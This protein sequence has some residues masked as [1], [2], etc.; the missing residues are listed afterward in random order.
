MLC[1]LTT[2][3]VVTAE[4][5]GAALRSATATTFDR[6]DSDGCMSTNDTVILLASGASGVQVS[7]A[8]LTSAVTEASA[9]LSSART[10]EASVTAEVSAARDT[11]TPLA[12]EAS[13]ITVSFV[14]MQPSESIRSKVVAVAERSAAPA[15]SAVTTAS[16]VSTQSIV[17]SPGASIPAPLAMP[18]TDQPAPSMCTVFGTESVVMIAC[19]A[20]GP[21]S[22]A[23]A[24]VAPDG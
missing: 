4:D 14:D 9:V 8:A 5:A 6:I 15:S 22:G 3:A 18:P 13:R 23:S 12:P 17:A 16:V 7:R 11:W 19:A 2:D 21:P 1:V 24:V 10:A 20:A